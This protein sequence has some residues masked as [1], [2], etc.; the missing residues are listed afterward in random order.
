[1]NKCGFQIVEFFPH[2]HPDPHGHNSE[3]QGPPDLMFAFEKQR[4]AGAGEHGA[5]LR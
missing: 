2:G 3:G 5:D 4:M 1:M